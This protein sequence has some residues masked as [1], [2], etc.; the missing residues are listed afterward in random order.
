MDGEGGPAYLLRLSRSESTA[1][2]VSYKSRAGKGFLVNGREQL[3]QVLEDTHRFQPTSHPFQLAR[4]QA[5]AAGKHFLGGKLS[6]EQRLLALTTTQ[7]KASAGLD[8]LHNTQLYR[9]AAFTC[10]RVFRSILFNDDSAIDSWKVAEAVDA[11]ER[12]RAA[13]NRIK[14]HVAGEGVL[15]DNNTAYGVLAHLAQE[16]QSRQGTVPSPAMTHAIVETLLNAVAPAA[17][18]LYW[19]LSLLGND[20]EVQA[21]LR[22]EVEQSLNATSAE[23]RLPRYALRQDTYMSQCIRESL[24]L[25]PPAWIIGRRCVADVTLKSVH[26]PGGSHVL[27]SPF[28]VHR[29]HEC[30]DHP[31]QFRPERFTGRMPHR[32]SYFPFGSGPKR[33]PASAATIPVLA[34]IVALAVARGPFSVCELSRPVGLLT[35]RPAVDAS[36]TYH[37]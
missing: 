36:I 1:S 8:L 28:V 19:T 33:C 6:T 7:A 27:V 15:V 9:T 10:E 12:Q 11:I 31:D 18:S 17:S 14:S 4:N 5:S 26:I 22:A 29:V 34:T 16:I 32:H 3:G 21:K 35:L 13:P 24:R 23:D 30:W 2:V 37:L 20:L 25:Y